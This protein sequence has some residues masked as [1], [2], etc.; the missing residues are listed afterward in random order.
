MGRNST[1]G[2]PGEKNR[3]ESGGSKRWQVRNISESSWRGRQE[4]P[5]MALHAALRSL[6]F[7]LRERLGETGC[8]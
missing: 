4:S 3:V 7:I 5:D 2:S 6:R 8:R 1:G